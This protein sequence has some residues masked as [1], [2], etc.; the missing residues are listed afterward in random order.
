MILW[1]F[2][3]LD[4]LVLTTITLTQFTSA[5]TFP[6]LLSSITYLGAKGFLFFGE[7]MSTIDLF[8][9][10]YL[11]LMIFGVKIIFAY[12]L[13]LGWFLYKLLFTLLS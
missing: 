4:A 8:I 12:Y 3:I 5:S 7:P 2:I 11:I 13:M 6:L 10:V 9:A 1:I